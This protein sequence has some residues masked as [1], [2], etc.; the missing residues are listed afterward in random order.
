MKENIQIR[1]LINNE[2]YRVISE[3]SA[4]VTILREAIHDALIECAYRSHAHRWNCEVDGNPRSALF[5]SLTYYGMSSREYAYFL[6]LSTASAVR[7]IARACA[8]G[9]LRSCSCD[10]SKAGPLLA[11][12]R[13]IWANCANRIGSDNLRYAV[14]ISKRLIDRQFSCLFPITISHIFLH[15][16][17]VG[18]TVRCYFTNFF[19]KFGSRVKLKTKC[20]CVSAF[21]SCLRRRCSARVEELSQIGD[22]LMESLLHSRRIRRSNTTPHSQRGV[23]I[24]THQER[25]MK[26]K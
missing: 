5:P 8:M 13:D 9:R 17:A 14:K 25:Y 4:L 23:C 22:F 18:R 7:S 1:G 26:H 12:Q 2:T 3:D 21:G 16:I 15:N 20:D 24:R 10:P 6:A 19:L 11:D